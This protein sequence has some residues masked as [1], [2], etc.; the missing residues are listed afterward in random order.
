MGVGWDVLQTVILHRA[1]DGE[2]VEALEI[3]F[4]YSQDFVHD[5]VE[6]ASDSCPSYACCFRFEVEELAYEAC[7]PE[8]SFVKPGSPFLDS[9]FEFG[10]HS[11]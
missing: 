7:F 11:Q 2:M 1:S 6:E 10:D 8:E 3:L 5:I 4:F 9:A